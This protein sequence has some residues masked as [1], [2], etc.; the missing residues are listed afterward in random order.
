MFRVLIFGRTQH[1]FSSVPLSK[2]PYR[3]HRKSSREKV[4]WEDDQ[5]FPVKKVATLTVALFAIAGGSMMTW[6][7][8]EGET[9]PKCKRTRKWSNRSQ[10]EDCHHWRRLCW[11]R[12]CSQVGKVLSCNSGESVRSMA[13]DAICCAITHNSKRRKIQSARESGYSLRA[14]PPKDRYSNRFGE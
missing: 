11:S 9:V 4:N 14:I 6:K 7:W 13:S 3:T 8:A 12:F 2:S 1:R 5:V 10:Q